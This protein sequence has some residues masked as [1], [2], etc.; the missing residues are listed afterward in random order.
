MNLKDGKSW[1][2]RSKL[3]KRLVEPHEKKKKYLQS[4]KDIMLTLYM[5]GMSEQQLSVA[6]GLVSAL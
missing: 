1:M 5:G 4:G 2:R 6:M 3:Y